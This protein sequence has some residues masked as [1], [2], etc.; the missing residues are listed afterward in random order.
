MYFMTLGIIFKAFCMYF[1]LLFIICDQIY[2]D[3]PYTYIM[4]RHNLTA[5]QWLYQ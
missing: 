2:K 5:N 3:T 1:T 4:T